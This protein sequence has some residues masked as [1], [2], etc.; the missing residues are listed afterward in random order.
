MHG[1]HDLEPLVKDLVAK[2]AIE[3][4]PQP[5]VALKLQKLITGGQFGTAELAKVVGEDQSLAATLL[6][7]ANSARYRGYEQITSLHDAI[8]RVGASEVTRTALAMGMAPLASAPGPL[9]ELRRKWWTDAYMA[10]LCAQHLGDRRGLRR[11]EA[12]VCGLLHDFGRMFAVA[13]LERILKDTND[14]RVLPSSVWEASIDRLHVEL[15]VKV[16]QRWNLSA[17]LRA[18]IGTHHKPESAGLHRKMVDVVVAADGVVACAREHPW[19]TSRD[20]SPVPTLR[21]DEVNLLTGLIPQLAV[22]ATSFEEAGAAA[23]E[24]VVETTS[25]I[26]KPPTTLDGEPRRGGFT[27]QMR[28]GSQGRTFSGVYVTP[29]GL[30]FVGGGA[31]RQYSMVQLSVRHGEPDKPA[32]NQPHFSFPANVMLVVGDRER[33]RVEARLFGVDAEVMAEWTRFYASFA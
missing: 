22:L 15:G 9:S 24:P 4:P 23:P 6:R 32:G 27:V 1:A 16:A 7:Y 26:E 14:G 5:S 28:R 13:C 19:L 25:Q 21:P 29:D 8:T 30:A 31:P 10:A 12:F 33:Q 3:V 18:V 20:L 2:D 11:D 17:M